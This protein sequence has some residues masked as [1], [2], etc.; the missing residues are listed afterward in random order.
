M[1]EL[2]RNEYC[3]LAGIL[4]CLLLPSVES[5]AQNYPAKPV[6]ILVGFLPGGGADVVARMVAQKLTDDLGQPVVVENRPG[7]SGT[8]ATEATARASANGYTLQVISAAEPAQ[9]AL[10]PRLTYDLARS[11]MLIKLT[12]AQAE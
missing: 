1:Q 5:A 7:A 11:A 3:L 9:G 12:G 4:A 2:K 10:R 6:R 8:I